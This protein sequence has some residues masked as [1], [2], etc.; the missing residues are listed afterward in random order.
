LGGDVKAY[1]SFST[2]F[3]ARK[4]G[5]STNLS[6]SDWDIYNVM[7]GS[8]FRVLK[9]RFTLGLGLGWGSKVHGTGDPVEIGDERV[10]LIRQATFDYRMY[11]FVL[12]FSF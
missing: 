4:K 3:A 7:V 8:A 12:G 10:V 2:D 11:K 1:A 6:V 5:A 9:A